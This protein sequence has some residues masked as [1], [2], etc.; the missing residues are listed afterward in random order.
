MYIY[1]IILYIQ[2]SR[3]PISSCWQGLS[4]DVGRAIFRKGSKPIK[5]TASGQMKTSMEVRN[6]STS[7]DGQF[8]VSF[9]FGDCVHIIYDIHIFIKIYSDIIIYI[10]MR[11]TYIYD[12]YHTM[13]SILYTSI[14]YIHLHTV[15]RSRRSASD[16]RR[17]CRPGGVSM[18][19]G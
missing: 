6:K 10:N 9:A 17:F 12:L 16:M 5:T 18:V 11:M 2:G 3:V 7:G 14:Y 13:Y 1:W 4:T 8:L 15:A 19:P